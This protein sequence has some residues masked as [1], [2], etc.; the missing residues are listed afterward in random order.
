MGH[1]ANPRARRRF[2]K[3][4]PTGS[5][6]HDRQTQD[7]IAHCAANRLDLFSKRRYRSGLLS[8]FPNLPVPSR[9]PRPANGVPMEQRPI[10]VLLQALFRKARSW[11]LFQFAS[12][13]FVT[14]LFVMAATAR[15][16]AQQGLPL[17]PVFRDLAAVGVAVNPVQ[18]P[19]N[20]GTDQRTPSGGNASDP[21]H[22]FAN[23]GAGREQPPARRPRSLF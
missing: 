14:A 9:R 2:V 20:G 13:L 4:L 3:R 12:A 19:A 21:H 23:P 16:E 1:A 6:V 11:G 8:P 10:N 15:V 7:Q 17:P 18:Q 22:V 5:Q